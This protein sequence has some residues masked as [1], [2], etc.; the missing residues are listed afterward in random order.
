MEFS[1]HNLRLFA[2]LGYETKMYADVVPEKSFAAA[3]KVG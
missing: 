3:I 1:L 2:N